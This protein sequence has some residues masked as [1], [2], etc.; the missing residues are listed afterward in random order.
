MFYHNIIRP[1]LHNQKN[2]TYITKKTHKF[3]LPTLVLYQTAK[4]LHDKYCCHFLCVRKGK[5][6]PLPLRDNIVSK[7]FKNPKY[8]YGKWIN[9]I[10]FAKSKVLVLFVFIPSYKFKQY[11]LSS[12]KLY[13]KMYTNF[14]NFSNELWYIYVFLVV[15]IAASKYVLYRRRKVLK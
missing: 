7:F 12:K 13:T 5:N 10:N 4:A 8:F 9:V 15:K 6:H 3:W 11:F 1:T 2:T 14:Q